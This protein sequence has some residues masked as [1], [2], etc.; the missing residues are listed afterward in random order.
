VKPKTIAQ[1]WPDDRTGHAGSVAWTAPAI[2]PTQVASANSRDRSPSRIVC[3]TPSV[4]SRSDLATFLPNTPS[5][6]SA[7]GST[8][9]PPQPT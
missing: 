6:P 4:T 9:V 5:P 7:G 8:T 1:A 3:A 2:T